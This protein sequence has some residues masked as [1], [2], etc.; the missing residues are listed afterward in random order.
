[1]SNPAKRVAVRFSFVQRVISRFALEKKPTFKEA[2][3][4]VF[5]FLKKRGWK[6]Q[7]SLSVPHATS[8]DGKVR[9]WFKAQAVYAVHEDRGAEGSNPLQFKDSHSMSSD[10]R[11]NTDEAKFMSL[12]ERWTGYKG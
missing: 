5:G 12:V 6:I 10:L 7:E 11:D 3:E 8:P 2:R 4:K 1:M 9:L